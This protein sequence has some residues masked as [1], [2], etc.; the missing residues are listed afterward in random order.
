MESRH[1]PNQ[2]S[3][4]HTPETLDP[5]SH[6]L[7]RPPF[8]FT[9]GAFHSVEAFT[10]RINPTPEIPLKAWTPRHSDYDNPPF[11]FSTAALHSVESSESPN[12][13]KP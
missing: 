13:A 9:I 10:P 2:T 11:I 1:T 7:R 6:R 3:A 12:H 5:V 8:I 4:Q